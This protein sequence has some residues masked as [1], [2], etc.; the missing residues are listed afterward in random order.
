VGDGE[1]EARR[2][3]EEHAVVRLGPLGPA[4]EDEDDSDRRQ[5][6]L[7]PEHR[8]DRVIGAVLARARLAGH[9]EHREAQ[10]REPDADPLPALELEPEVALG[11]HAEHHEPAG[12]HGLYERHRRERE[13]PDVQEVRD[14]R[15]RVA[16][17]PPLGPE[18]RGGGA[19]R[20]P[21]VYVRRGDRAAMAQQKADLRNQRREAGQNEPQEERHLPPLPGARSAY[22]D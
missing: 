16:D 15:E 19:Q 3:A 4:G 5:G 22:T 9:G 13:R 8:G 6:G 20:V 11:H 18:Q 21:D 14:D 7:E 1:E 17:R 2:E 10:R 12:E